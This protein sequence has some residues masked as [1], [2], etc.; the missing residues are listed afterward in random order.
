MIDW[1]NIS[2]VLLDMDGT[3]LDLHFDNFFWRQHV[4]VRYAEKNQLHIDD[5]HE[6]LVPLFKSHEGTMNWYCVDFWSDKLGRDIAQLKAEIDHLI[7]VHPHVIEFLDAV[8]QH[9]KKIV[10]V[11]NAHQKSLMLKMDKTSLHHHFDEMICAHDFGAPKEDPSFWKKL[12]SK[13]D[14]DKRHTLLVDDTLSVLRSAR[15]YG[16]AYNLAVLNPDSKGP[17]RD[18]GEFD[19][20]RDFRDITPG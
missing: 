9:D 11:T 13:L 2:T 16:I 3:L 10:L 14:F 5:A 12:N 20:I 17:E 6:Y 7:A 15:N 8:R 1:N 4:P 19:A 18:T